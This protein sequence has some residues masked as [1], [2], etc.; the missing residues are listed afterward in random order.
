MT[1]PTSQDAGAGV[2]LMRSSV[3][4]GFSL[5]ELMI[6]LA[7]LGF[8]MILAATMFPVGWMRAR[9]LNEHT[10]I[11]AASNNA[12]A[13]LAMLLNP[14]DP[15][16]SGAEFA[17][18][19][20]FDGEFP[21]QTLQKMVFESDMRVHQLH[22]Q[23]MVI[24]QSR[25]FV[26][27]NPWRLEG[28]DA[29]NDLSG[30]NPDIRAKLLL[31]EF[32]TRSFYTPRIL[33]HERLYPPLSRRSSADLTQVDEIW[34]QSFDGRVYSWAAFHRLRNPIGP[35]WDDPNLTDEQKLALASEA[36]ADARVF[37]MYYVALRRPR[38]TYRYAVQNPATAPNP[39]NRGAFAQA[40]MPL[41]AS[42]DVALPTAWRAQI[43]F[44]EETDAYSWKTEFGD[45]PPDDYIPP[46]GVYTEVTVD[47]QG[48]DW[49]PELF[50][51]GS[52]LIDEVNGLVYTVT[53]RRINASDEDRAVLT[54]D[55]EV[56]LE[57]IDDSAEID[58]VPLAGNFR[59]DPDEFK[60]VVWVFPPP[61]L[62]RAGL[63]D[64]GALT[65]QGKQPVVGIEVKTLS[66]SP[67]N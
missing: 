38:A 21:Y 31:P 29:V 40:P 14:S 64:Q 2:A 37:D 9:E 48:K 32:T 49:V 23:N 12:H 43:L 8:G 18:D 62:D 65:F 4:G 16:L 15:G 57:D 47:G 25:A 27:E 6:A 20:I 61:V 50:Q 59:V 63:G 19:L 5:V 46:A 24:G 10:V 66:V 67:S 41:N 3:R 44:P 45:N 11:T 34:D 56:F 35:R 51:V 36:A 28:V 26:N 13:K 30:L 55:R 22:M 33:F 58:P 54:L 17:G 7:I 1:R 60:R 39:N 52:V 53:D 42:E